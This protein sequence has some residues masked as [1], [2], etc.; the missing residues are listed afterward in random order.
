MSLFLLKDCF[1]FTAFWIFLHGLLIVLREL[2]HFLESAFMGVI[3]SKSDKKLFD[4][5]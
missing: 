5:D 4:E 2:E 1:N 3:R